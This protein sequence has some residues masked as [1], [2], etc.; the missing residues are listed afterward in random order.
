MAVDLS[1][2]V[3]V[4]KGGREGNALEDEYRNLNYGYTFHLKAKNYFNTP[5]LL[6]VDYGDLVLHVKSVKP[7]PAKVVTVNQSASL[8]VRE[9]H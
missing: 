8:R 4:G 5:K 1:A 6:P 3:R 7:P 9:H 2:D